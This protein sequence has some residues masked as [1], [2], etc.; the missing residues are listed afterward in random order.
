[1]LHLFG[2][3][4]YE[5]EVYLLLIKYKALTAPKI[6][7][8]SKVPITRVYD[9]TNS[10]TQK[11]LVALVDVKP[12]TYKLLPFASSFKTLISLK[13]E[14]FQKEVSLLKDRYNSLIKDFSTI[15]ETSLP[16]AEDFVF[17][18]R[19]YE[20]IAKTWHTIF[21]NAKKEVFI[22]NTDPSWIGSDILPMLEAMVSKDIDVRVLSVSKDLDELK[23]AAKI[24]VKI[25]LTQNIL[26]GFVAD[27]KYFLVSKQLGGAAKKEQHSCFLTEYDEMVNS[28][29]E[30]FL[31][32]WGEAKKL[33]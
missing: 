7:E 6:A 28:A 25:G 1:M 21:R 9:I 22:F 31:M 14:N 10:L 17:T 4:K 2:M 20:A 19:G 3:S 11:G 30:Y 26:R 27:K 33:N 8:L 18:I 5:A 23:K 29:R 12:K 16:E 24:G 32:K 13:I 15:P